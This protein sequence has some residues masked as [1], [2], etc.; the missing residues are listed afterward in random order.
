MVYFQ[1]NLLLASP[2]KQLLWCGGSRFDFSGFSDLCSTKTL[3][4]I[5]YSALQRTTPALLCTTLKVLLWCFPDLQSMIS[6]LL[7]P[8]TEDQY[9]KVLFQ[10]YLLFHAQYFPRNLAIVLKVTLENQQIVRLERV[11]LPS[12]LSKYHTCHKIFRRR[13]QM[14][15]CEVFPPIKNNLKISENIQR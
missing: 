15:L 4:Q 6:A 9:Y 5:D 3:L 14:K 8:T 12:N 2:K 10:Y 13:I 7:C 11:K 1:W